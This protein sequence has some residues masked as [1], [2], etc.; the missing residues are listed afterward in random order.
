MHVARKQKIFIK[1]HLNGKI[2]LDNISKI[3][4]KKSLFFC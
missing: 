3:W 4:I 2:G 1:Y